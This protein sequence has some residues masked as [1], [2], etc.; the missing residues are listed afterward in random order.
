MLADGVLRAIAMLQITPDQQTIDEI[1]SY[2]LQLDVSD[3]SR[4]WIAAAAPGWP[5][6]VTREY[7]KEC[8]SS[9]NQKIKRAAEAALKNKHLKWSPLWQTTLFPFRGSVSTNDRYIRRMIY[10]LVQCRFQH[11]CFGNRTHFN[12]FPIFFMAITKELPTTVITTK[13]QVFAFEWTAVKIKDLTLLSLRHASASLWITSFPP[14]YKSASTLSF[15]QL[16]SL[17]T[18]KSV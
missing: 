13:G 1:I 15:D 3:N 12:V 10:K 14:D 2:G 9:E 6:D 18:P 5:S 7:L 11:Q 17:F 16:L 8:I 4:V